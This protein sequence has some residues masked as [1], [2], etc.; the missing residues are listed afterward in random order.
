V[1]VASGGPAPP[2]GRLRRRQR[3]AL[4]R[5]ASLP[6]SPPLSLHVTG[7]GIGEEISNRLGLGVGWMVDRASGSVL[8]TA[9]RRVESGGIERGKG[10]RKVGWRGG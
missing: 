9:A 3:A 7:G 10:R 4:P 5:T 6:P 8:S 1:C 2:H